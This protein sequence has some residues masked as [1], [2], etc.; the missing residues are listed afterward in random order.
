MEISRLKAPRQATFLLYFWLDPK[1]SKSQG[2]EFPKRSLRLHGMN[3]RP[4]LDDDKVVD[5]SQP[6]WLRIRKAPFHLA[7]REFKA[8]YQDPLKRSSK[9]F[10]TPKYPCTHL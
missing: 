2:G 4:R 8:G 1:G 3:P 5:K 10:G 9:P 7:N 6:A